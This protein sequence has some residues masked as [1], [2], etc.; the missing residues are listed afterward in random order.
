M[1]RCDCHQDF[2][3]FKCPYCG[4]CYLAQD[5]DDMDGLDRS[6]CCECGKHFYITEHRKVRYE[7][8]KGD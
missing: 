4:T 7:V 3:D 6:T 5:W 2:P 1:E 8:I